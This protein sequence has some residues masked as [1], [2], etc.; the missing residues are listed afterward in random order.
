MVFK[1]MLDLLAV[2]DVTLDHFLL[3]SEETK[4]EFT[5][6]K[7]SKDEFCFNYE[8][9]IPVEQ[10]VESVGGN[11]ANVAVGISRLGYKVALKTHLGNDYNG[12]KILE[13]LRKEKIETSYL[14]IDFDLPT[15][16]STIIALFGERL[17]FSY[18]QKRDYSWP[19]SLPQS[20]WFFLTS[21]G[22]GF[23][24]ILPQIIAY[25]RKR[26][27]RVV[28]SPGSYQL[29]LG[30]ATYQELLSLTELIIM[31]REEAE[32]F[33]GKKAAPRE[34]LED[35]RA[36]GPKI[37]V[38]T[39]GRKGAYF[40]SGS[41]GFWMDLVDKRERKEATGAG[42]AFLSGLLGALMEGLMYEQ[43]ML[44]GMLN[45]AS[46][47]QAIGAQ[48]GLLTKAAIRKLARESEP[49]ISYF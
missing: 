48:K 49:T 27:P 3:L 11:A 24:K 7:R 5:E 28:F 25:I 42:D 43:A 2:G 15:N 9:K 19:A 1:E 26:Q 34:L 45:S 31:N 16:N 14:Y 6:V 46:V 30:L 38:I 39:D 35:L 8:A 22:E 37:S 21:L 12:K 33:L 29:S 32:L 47:V 23:L 4:A 36:L 17:I 18:H 40:L 13:A 20:R 41:R 10:I 44:W